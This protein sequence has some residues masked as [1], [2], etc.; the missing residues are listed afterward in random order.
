MVFE[1]K[2]V[3][4][5][6]TIAV[7]AILIIAVFFLLK[8]V[9]ISV[10][11]GLILSYMFLPLYR[12]TLSLVRSKSLASTL[13]LILL[14]IIIIVPLWFITPL[15]LSQFF[16]I[17]KLIQNIDVSSFVKSV[18]PS[19]SDV[20]VAQIANT[21]SSLFSNAGSTGLEYLGKVFLEAPTILLH[22]FIIGFVFFFGLR[23][24]EDLK[25]IASE[26][27][28]FNKAKEKILIQN[29]KDI[30]NSVV[31]G[32]IIIGVVQGLL[33]GIGLLIFGVD[34]A[35]VLTVLAIVMSIIPIL[36]PYVVYIPVAVLMFANG[37]TSLGIAFLAYN[38]I[39]V[40]T[41]DNF[42]RSYIVSRKTKL[43]SAVVFVGMM[44]GLFAFGIAGLLLGPLILAYFL[45]ILQLYKEKELS[46]LF[47]SDEPEEV[48]SSEKK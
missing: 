43:N 46:S 33:A 18:L 8:P 11:I 3:T 47:S 27:S 14:L 32:H 38:L 45:I 13:M 36:G 40:S 25:K 28:R 44:G 31:Y 23:D 20:F 1:K 29:F 30:T 35:L 6:L 9:L 17:L 5:F 2:D 12:R 48:Q 39:I 37:Q 16:E 22:I 10:F 42:L 7:L 24:S 34:N 21:F 19:T 41:T 15:V 4:K 26:I